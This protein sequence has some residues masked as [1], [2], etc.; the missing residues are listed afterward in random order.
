M[1]MEDDVD[2][3]YSVDLY[4]DVDMARHGDNEKE[5]EK[6]E[7]DVGEKDEDEEDEDKEEDEDEDDGKEPQTIDLGDM[8]NTSAYDVDTMSDNQPIMLPEQ[9]QERCKSTPQPQPPVT[10]PQTQTLDPHRWPRYP[11]T[12]LLSGLLSV[13][14]VM[15]QD[16]RPQVPPLRDADAAGN[17]SD[18]DVAQHGLASRP[19]ATVYPMSLSRKSHSQKRI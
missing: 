18:V 14:P 4:S 9:G 15:R 17:S 7:D 19:V 6:Y 2:A 11:E 12:H 1:R 16:P 13:G 10:T 5:E 8:V 3:L